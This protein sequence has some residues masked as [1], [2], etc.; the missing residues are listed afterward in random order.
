MNAPVGQKEARVD[1]TSHAVTLS[2]F[3]LNKAGPKVNLK[4]FVVPVAQIGEFILKRE[5]WNSKGS[6]AENVQCSLGVCKCSCDGSI[7]RKLYTGRGSVV[8]GVA[9]V[10]VI[11]GCRGRSVAL[12]RWVVP[13]S[14]RYELAVVTKVNA[15][16]K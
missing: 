10:L 13:G 7:G 3:F 2:P 15:S 12:A 9:D 5:D 8:G 14:A 11:V 1:C 4:L 6:L 16:I